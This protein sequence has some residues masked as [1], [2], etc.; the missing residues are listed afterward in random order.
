MV[1]FFSLCPPKR[2]LARRMQPPRQMHRLALV[3]PM[4]RRWKKP[5]KTG[6]ALPLRQVTVKAQ[7]LEMIPRAKRRQTTSSRSQ[8]EATARGTRL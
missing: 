2:A 8:C 1:L 5:P 7:A 4:V 3:T 6:V